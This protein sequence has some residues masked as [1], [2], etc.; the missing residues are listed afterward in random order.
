MLTA[1]QGTNSPYDLAALARTVQ[2]LPDDL[3]D[4]QAQAALDPVLTA[5]TGTADAAA[6]RR[7]CRTLQELAQSISTALAAEL[8]EAQAQAALDAVLTA[9]TGTADTLYPRGAGQGIR[10]LAAELTEARRRRR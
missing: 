1:I 9:M 3:T 10:A 4:A 2:T 6:R 5:M 7:R 8:T